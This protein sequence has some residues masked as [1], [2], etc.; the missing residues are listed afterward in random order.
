MYDARTGEYVNEKYND[1]HYELTYDLNTY[2]F[3]RGQERHLFDFITTICS[4][5]NNSDR[6]RINEKFK[7]NLVV[8]AEKPKENEED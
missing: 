7:F 8:I 6:D 1:Y 3:E 2:I 4:T 5:M